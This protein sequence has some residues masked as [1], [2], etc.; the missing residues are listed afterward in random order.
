MRD[1]LAQHLLIQ[2][3]ADLLDMAGLF[4]AQQIAGA[5]NIEVVAGELEA[6]AKRDPATAALPAAVRLRRDLAVGGI[7]KSA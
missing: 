6:G 7:V 2:L 5:A 3:V 1:R 4:L